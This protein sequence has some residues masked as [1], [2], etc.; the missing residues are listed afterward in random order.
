MDLVTWDEILLVGDILVYN[1]ERRNDEKVMMVLLV[2]LGDCLRVKY[3]PAW[4]YCFGL[5]LRQEKGGQFGF[6]EDIYGL[7]EA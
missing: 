2:L 4:L 6:W 1:G 7:S 3:Q 5:C